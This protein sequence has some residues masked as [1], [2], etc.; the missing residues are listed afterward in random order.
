ML[1]EAERVVTVTIELLVRQ[2]T[3]VTNTWQCDGQ[4]TIQELPHAVATK[5]NAST[6]WHAFTELEVSDGLLGTA[7]LWL[8]TGDQGEVLK[9]AVDQLGVTSSVAD[10]HVDNNLD[11]TRDLHDVLVGELIVELGA[12]LFAV[13]GLQTW[14]VVLAH[15]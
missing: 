6:D 9:C 5:G 12:D 13:A 10:T 11:N 4:Q 8:L 14:S 1:G 7:K 15:D 3:E 2:A